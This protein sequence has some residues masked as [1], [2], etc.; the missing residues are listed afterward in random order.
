VVVDTRGR[1]RRRA[2][3]GSGHGSRHPTRA[4]ERRSPLP[5]GLLDNAFSLE[6][7][8]AGARRGAPVP[9]CRYA[10]SAWSG[11]AAEPRVLAE[12]VP[13][14]PPRAGS[15]TAVY[16]LALWDADGAPIAHIAG[17][18]Q[19][20]GRSGTVPAR[21]AGARAPRRRLRSPRRSS[22][23]PSRSRA[24]APRPGPRDS[25]SPAGPE[26]VVARIRALAQTERPATI[27]RPGMRRGGP[28]ARPASADAREPPAR[29]GELG[30]DFADG[31]GGPQRPQPAAT[32]LAAVR[33]RSR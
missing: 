16:A 4:A 20:A 25:G 3:P 5:R 28:R 26:P 30:L 18:R 31:D 11:T 27:A 29:A 7:D 1:P 21:D 14:R 24:P 8:L 12:S 13:R 2:E 32:G 10:S 22:A 33:P 9:G 23:R 17:L 19:R 15:D 6:R